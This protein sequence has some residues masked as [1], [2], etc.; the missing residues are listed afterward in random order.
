MHRRG[1]RIT[2]STIVCAV[3]FRAWC[4]REPG[5]VS[6]LAAWSLNEAAGEPRILLHA[7]THGS[8]GGA[9]HLRRLHLLLLEARGT[10]SGDGCAGTHGASG[11]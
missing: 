2:E 1:A 3:F 6:Y 8:D 4:T 7:A 11:R 5:E 10:R 9:S